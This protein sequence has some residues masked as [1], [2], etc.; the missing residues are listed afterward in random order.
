MACTNCSWEQ[1]LA[2]EGTPSCTDDMDEQIMADYEACA[3]NCKSEC[4]DAVASLYACGKPVV[5]G[6]GKTD[7]AF[8]IA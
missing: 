5:C 7:V 8:E 6:E 3:D 2:V 4:D 1:L